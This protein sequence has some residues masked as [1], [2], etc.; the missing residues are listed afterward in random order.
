[1]RR[2]LILG[3]GTM[4]IPAFRAAA[5][6]GV[7]VVTID[8][9]PN[10]P[11]LPL[12]RA[13]FCYDLADLDACL[14]VARDQDVSGVMTLAAD[15]P[16]PAVAE[17]CEKLDLAG[18]KKKAVRAATHKAEM[19]RVLASAGV[20]VPRTISAATADEADS[21]VR[22]LGGEAILKPTDSSGG[23]GVTS[24]G[25]DPTPA[26]VRKAFE[27]AV[28]FGRC[29][30]V[31]VA[32]LVEG[33]EYSVET[34]TWR[35]RTTIVAVTEKLT[36]GPPYHVEIGHSQPPRL[37]YADIALL[38]DIAAAGIA[39]LGIDDAP[40]HTEIRIP[41]LK[42]KLP[43][44]EPPTSLDS[45]DANRFR[46]FDSLTSFFKNAAQSEP[47]NATQSGLRN[48]AQS[49]PRN[50]ARS[51]SR[52]VARSEPWNVERSEP[53]RFDDDRPRQRLCPVLDPV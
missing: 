6:L 22:L 42:A 24:F 13:S 40:G 8:P 23:R 9:S 38:G 29:G 15:Y 47:R 25:P 16:I 3:A 30:D 49:E 45:P 34:L 32:E 28:G 36:T 43:G 50:V 17:L 1:M 48:V 33:P 31:V 12:A 10:A 4:Q 18:P 7:E 14:K 53:C 21:A 27:R 20:P 19:H 37:D 5:E 52:N 35:G 26:E 44:L 51:G 46:L 2:L 11:A 41:E 39:A